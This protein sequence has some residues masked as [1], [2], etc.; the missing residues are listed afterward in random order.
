MTNT[1]G[2]ACHQTC[3]S[4]MNPE[5]LRICFINTGTHSS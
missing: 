1:R 2:F 3:A 5:D 4:T